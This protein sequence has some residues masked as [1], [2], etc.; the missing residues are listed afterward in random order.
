MRSRDG[1]RVVLCICNF[2]PVIRHGYR[3]G[4][5]G[6]GTYRERLNTDS[7]YYGGSKH[8]TRIAASAGFIAACFEQIFM[9][10]IL[11][12]YNAQI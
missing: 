1:S 3:I 10:K 4:A 11:Q 2:T 8:G 9:I 7:H 12:H 6:P 5:P